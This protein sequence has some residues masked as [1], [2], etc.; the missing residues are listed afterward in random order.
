MIIII[1]HVCVNNIS[2]LDKRNRI[3]HFG[4]TKPPNNES[5]NTEIA[6]V[7]VEARNVRKIAAIARNID[8]HERLN[9]KKIRNCRKNLKESNTYHQK[10]FTQLNLDLSFEG[11]FKIEIIYLPTSGL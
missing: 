3:V 1:L 4:I 8:T 2:E 5:S 9:V 6:P 10:Q 7:S 11:I